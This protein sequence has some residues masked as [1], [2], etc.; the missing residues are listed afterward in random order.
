MADPLFWLVLSL[1]FVTVSLTIALVVAVPALKELA[2]A[3]RSADKLFETLRREFPPTLQAIRTMGIE[4]SDLTGDVS[5]G[6]QS[7]GNVVKQVDQSLTTVRKQA[8]KVNVGTRSLMVGVKA[9]WRT[10]TQPTKVAPAKTMPVRRAP[11]RLPPSL[12]RSEVNLHT[13]VPELE[14]RD[15]HGPVNGRINGIN[16]PS[17]DG[18]GLD[19]QGLRSSIVEGDRPLSDMSHLPSAPLPPSEHKFR[20][21]DSV[22]AKASGVPA[23]HMNGAHMNGAHMNGAH[24]NGAH[25]NDLS[26][27]GAER[28]IYPNG[29]VHPR[30]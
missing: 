6:V 3:A 30:A 1:L 9:A 2:R 5:E 24:M 10:F 8:Q 12:P 21:E 26:T 17:L 16:G 15:T 23:A 20:A 14:A 11:E 22:L 13:A 29:P 18:Q 27:I 25:A 19:G 28:T 4:V 7:A